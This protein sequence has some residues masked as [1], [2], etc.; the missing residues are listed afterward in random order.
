[1]K[2]PLMLILGYTGQLLFGGRF[3]IQWLVSERKGRSVIPLAFWLLSLAGGLLML[4]YAILR[5]D[6]VFIVGQ[7]AGL[8]V[9]LRNLMLIRKEAL[10]DVREIGA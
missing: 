2:E 10:R 7:A 6:Q 9:Y 8:A 4:G 5:R 1:M 3:V